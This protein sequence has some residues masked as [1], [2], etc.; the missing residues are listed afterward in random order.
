MDRYFELNKKITCACSI[1]EY[2]V[3]YKNNLT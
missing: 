3:L 1:P 2:P